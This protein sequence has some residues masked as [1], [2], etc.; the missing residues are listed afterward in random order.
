MLVHVVEARH[1][2]GHRVWLRFNDGLEGE[3]DLATALRGPV[4]RPLEDADYFARFI[5]DDTLT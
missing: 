1:C 5:L 4:F 2:G 3:I